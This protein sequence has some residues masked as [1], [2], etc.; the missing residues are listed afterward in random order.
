MKSVFKNGIISQHIFYYNY[1][2]RLIV[3]KKYLCNT[4]ELY[5]NVENKTNE[6]E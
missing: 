6:I 1:N 5:K 4:C 3:P 2:S